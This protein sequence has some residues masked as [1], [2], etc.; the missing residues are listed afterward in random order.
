[1]SDNDFSKYLKHTSR[2][3]F[4]G[5]NFNL[6]M[7]INQ[8][9]NLVKSCD[10]FYHQSSNEIK[11]E[12]KYI[13]NDYY[14]RKLSFIMNSIENSDSPLEIISFEDKQEKLTSN[15]II[16]KTFNKKRYINSSIVKSFKNMMKERYKICFNKNKKMKVKDK[17]L[18]NVFIANIQIGNCNNLQK[19][20]K[21]E[22]NSIV[23]ESNKTIAN[24]NILL[25]N[26]SV[27]EL[28]QF[29]QKG[30]PRSEM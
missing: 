10:V 12:R 19:H 7:S 17:N 16:Y 23:K 28:E 3:S 11:L 2:L 4:N 9:N 27:H 15:K 21:I 20:S 14:E 22:N 5:T 1:M 6:K 25:E 26:Y 24:K 29:L 30:I 8:R 18:G 13:K